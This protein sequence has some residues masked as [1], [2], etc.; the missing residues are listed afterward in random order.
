L[1]SGKHWEGRRGIGQPVSLLL[2]SA[3]GLVKETKGQ[4][5]L[6]NC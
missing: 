2:A 6:A 3:E 5:I 1:G 4:E